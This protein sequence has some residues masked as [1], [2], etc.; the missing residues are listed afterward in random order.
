M[1]KCD[2]F[3]RMRNSRSTLNSTR[4]FFGCKVSNKN[5]GCDYFTWID[6]SPVT[7]DH[8]FFGMVSCLMNNFKDGENLCDRLKKKLKDV[9]EERD[10]LSEKLNDCEK[11]LTALKQKFKEVK[12][13][14]EMCKA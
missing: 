7:V 14:E 2:D 11:K 9:E 3:C 5:G 1:P 13:R 10:T 6:S 4:R 12:T 8:Q